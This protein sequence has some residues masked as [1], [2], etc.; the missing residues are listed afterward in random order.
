MVEFILSFIIL[1]GGSFQ[2]L[3]LRA[4]EQLTPESQQHLNVGHL[5]TSFLD[6][7]PGHFLLAFAAPTKS[8]E[9]A[10]CIKNELAI[11]PSSLLAYSRV[12]LVVESGGIRC[13]V[14][15]EW[16]EVGGIAL[17]HLE[18]LM[19][20]PGVYTVAQLQEVIHHELFHF[21]DHSMG[22]K[23]LDVEWM[24]LNESS[25]KYQVIRRF[26]VEKPR[27]PGF[28]SDYA[29]SNAGEDKAETFAWM[30]CYPD[31]VNRLVA[32]DQI[33]A[34]KVNCLKRRIQ[35]IC[36]DVNEAF[37]TRMAKRRN[38]GLK[39]I[40]EEQQKLLT[41]LLQFKAELQKQEARMQLMWIELQLKKTF[42]SK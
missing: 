11:Y 32:N 6:P 25:F 28:V 20:D 10:S 15:G 3:Q 12:K 26:T 1:A 40:D 4:G 36:P 37:W 9:S 30:I 14:G 13:K 23:D 38:E 35:S 21:V 18:L 19:L 42:G 22:M 27:P 31:I 5:S 8:P 39:A 2:P 33:V 24:S 17:T 34:R 16:Y 41:E 29:T 7:K